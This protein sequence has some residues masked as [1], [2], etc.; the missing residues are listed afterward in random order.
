MYGKAWIAIAYA[1]AVAVQVALGG[2]GR[3]EADEWV[4][5]GIA[6]ATAVAVYMVPITTNYKWMKTAVAVVLALLQ[7]LATVLL[8]GLEPNDWLTLVLAALGA[9]GV[10]FAPATSFNP[11]GTGN[12]SVPFGTDH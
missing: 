1:V 10:F 7:A 8:D 9:I 11:S 5:M 4:Q 6:L 3:I 2:D 12:V